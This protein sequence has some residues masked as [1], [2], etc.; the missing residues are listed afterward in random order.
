MPETVWAF[1]GMRNYKDE[2]IKYLKYRKHMQ[3]VENACMHL[4]NS[5][6]RQACKY[7]NVDIV[8]RTNY[9]K[10]NKYLLKL[11]NGTK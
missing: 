7:G 11:R 9:L 4:R 3:Y 8:T 6:C 10:Y 2:L 5:I 1:V